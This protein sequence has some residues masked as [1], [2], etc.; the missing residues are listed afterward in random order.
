MY[1]SHFGLTGPPFQVTPDPSFVF[2]GKAY[3][4]AIEAL[5]E[6]LA[7]GVKAMIVTGEPGVGKTTLLNEFRASV[8]AGA[9]LTVPISAT[10]LDS[11]TLADRISY[12]LGQPRLADPAARREALLARLHSAPT[13]TLLVIDEAQHLLPGAF[14]LLET[15]ANGSASA[16]GRLQICLL[17]QPELR[18]R[19]DSADGGRFRELVGVDR[20]LGPLEQPEIRLYVEHRLHRAGWSGRPE[21]EDAA[22]FEIFVFTIGVPRRV[23]LLCDSLMLAA[24][25]E[26]RAR[27]DAPAVSRGAAAIRS[28]SFPA[29]IELLADEPPSFEAASRGSPPGLATTTPAWSEPA[30]PAGAGPATPPALPDAAA[31]RPRPAGRRRPPWLIPAAASV[32]TVLM[33]MGIL[34]VVDRQGATPVRSSAEPSTL[35]SGR[36]TGRV[37]P[38][39]TLAEEARVPDEPVSAAAPTVPIPGVADVTPAGPAPPETAPEPPRPANPAPASSPTQ[40]ACSDPALALGLCDTENSSSTGRR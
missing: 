11:E 38:A 40:S 9:T 12:V 14:E 21:F 34:Y 37:T 19:L 36:A 3:R 5:R 15:L 27:I 4:G 28:G 20:H 7:T 30:P 18:M 16:A 29:A 35:A 6:G 17:G 8:D 22:F 13:A 23:N 32:V 2:H 33:A 31:H 25:L 24:C 10:E 26:K 39:T 1:E